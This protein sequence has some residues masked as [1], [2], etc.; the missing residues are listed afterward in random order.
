[1]KKKKQKYSIPVVRGRQNGRVM[2]QGYLTPGALKQMIEV[3]RFI[4]PANL[5][6]GRRNGSQ[7]SGRD[8]D[9]KKFAKGILSKDS[10]CTNSVWL[11]DR[12]GTITYKSSSR[13]APDIG[14]LTFDDSCTLYVPDGQAR[15]LGLIKAKDEYD[16]RNLLV[17]FQM[18]VVITQMKRLD[19]DRGTIDINDNSRRMNKVQRAAI[20]H[21]MM[22]F[23][24]KGSLKDPTERREAITY[25]A[26]SIL[27]Q[28]KDSPLYDMFVFP[29]KPPYT[30]PQIKAVASRK[31]F[32]KIQSAS[33]LDALGNKNNGNIFPY[34]EAHHFSEDMT[35]E[36]QCAVL[37]RLLW[38][39]WDALR[40]I[41]HK[42]W[43]DPNDYSFFAAIG[44]LSQGYLFRY[45][46]ELIHKNRLKPTKQNFTKYLS[47]IPLLRQPE[48]WYNRGGVERHPK[49]D[50]VKT[51][52]DK[53][54]TSYGR[55]VASIMKHQL[56][57]RLG[58]S[59]V[60]QSSRMHSGKTRTKKTIKKVSKARQ[61][62]VKK[63]AKK[64]AK[65]AR[66]K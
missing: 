24:R 29:Y 3:D 46:L 2:Y 6:R 39:F 45:M 57:K 28:S 14:T 20:K 12:E 50:P 32:R 16:V 37:A 47:M 43:N 11:N 4:D 35:P 13:T 7:R 27:D 62:K 36:E 44:S 61:P 33:F 53:R 52:E 30:K 5:A 19:E 26:L 60:I 21:G 63:V 49:V 15:I 34:L 58:E 66:K 51:M 65:K 22:C 40:D 9:I 56:E 38:N 55:V 48:R 1:M 54:G 59:I 10:F 8:G 42:M 17:D 41:T 18:P 64:V 31:Y 23:E 25:G